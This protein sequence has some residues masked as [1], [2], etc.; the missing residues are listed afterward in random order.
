MMLNHCGTPLVTQ[1]D[2]PAQNEG[3]DVS[4]AASECP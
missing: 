2:I 1:Y 4:L 3:M